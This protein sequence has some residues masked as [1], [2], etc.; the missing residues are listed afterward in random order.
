MSQKLIDIKGNKYGL[1][2]VLEYVGNEK[3]K[4]QCECG[5]IVFATGTSLRKGRRT[6]CGCNRKTRLI[7]LTGQKFGRL[8]VKEIDFSK[9]YK[10]VHWICECDCGNIISV[11]ACNLKKGTNSCGCLKLELLSK[12]KGKHYM[13]NTKIYGVWSSMKSRCYNKNAKS[14]KDYGAKGITV[15]DEWRNDFGSFYEWSVINGY[16]EGLQIDRIDNEKGYSP[17]NCRWVT[18]KENMNNTSKNVIVSYNGESHTL[19]EWG[20]ILGIRGGLIS[21]RLNNGGNVEDALFGKNKFD[22]KSS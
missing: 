8:T 17:Q 5:N 1:L 3:W 10:R 9:E 19:S 21:Q 16:K 11:S 12:T 18:R 15:C 13:T 7:D 14:Y 20:K 4:C 22:T 2:T 6:N